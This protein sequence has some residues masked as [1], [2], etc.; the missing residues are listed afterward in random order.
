MT[1]QLAEDLDHTL[2]RAADSLTLARHIRRAIMERVAH[3]AAS[4]CLWRP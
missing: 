3:P 1:T 4:D 2:A